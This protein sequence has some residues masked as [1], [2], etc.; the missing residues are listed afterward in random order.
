MG[1]SVSLG[2]SASCSECARRLFIIPFI[3][4]TH[5]RFSF[6]IILPI[7]FH[8]DTVCQHTDSSLSDNASIHL[9]IQHAH[10]RN[11]TVSGGLRAMLAVCTDHPETSN[12]TFHAS[13]RQAHEASLTWPSVKIS[14]RRRM[15]ADTNRQRTQ[16]VPSMA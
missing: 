2:S 4:L 16:P 11:S 14:Q 13:R 7:H 6:C 8:V 3:K 1:Q 5:R 12:G 9:R 15:C 10:W